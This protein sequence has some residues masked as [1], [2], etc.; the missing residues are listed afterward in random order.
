MSI[1]DQENAINA[2]YDKLKTKIEAKELVKGYTQVDKEKEIAE[3]EA[4]EI[5]EEYTQEDKEKEIAAINAKQLITPY[6]QEDKDNELKANEAAREAELKKIDDDFDALLKNMFKE[7]KGFNNDY[8]NTIIENLDFTV[9]DPIE[10]DND[11]IE[12]TMYTL[13]QIADNA[14]FIYLTGPTK[15]NA[16][17]ELSETEYSKY[18]SAYDAIVNKYD[19]LKAEIEAKKLIE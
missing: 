9:P 15:Y 18:A 12:S 13:S 14:K 2:K 19:K 1:I 7:T 10:I 3:I 17:N 8:V 5:T 4:K 16:L 11:T 6:T